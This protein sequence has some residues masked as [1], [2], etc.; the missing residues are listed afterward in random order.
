MHI[1]ILVLFI[2][3]LIILIIIKGIKII[4][5][6]ILALL[7][8]F[9]WNPSRKNNFYWL[10]VCKVIFCRVNEPRGIIRCRDI[11]HIVTAGRDCGVV[12]KK[13]RPG[14]H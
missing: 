7:M 6:F 1:N 11:E 4:S 5:I 9:T 8:P 3:H 12:I 2:T 13:L 10:V 14:C